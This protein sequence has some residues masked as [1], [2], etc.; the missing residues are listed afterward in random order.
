ML[1]KVVTLANL[2][3]E[4]NLILNCTLTMPYVVVLSYILVLSLQNAKN[5]LYSIIDYLDTFILII[6][7]IKL[8]AVQWDVDIVILQVKGSQSV[9]GGTVLSIVITKQLKALLSRVAAIEITLY[10]SIQPK[11]VQ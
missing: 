9:I 3:N 4:V 8:S 2:I 7:P 11:E 1:I 6:M 10:C 5:W